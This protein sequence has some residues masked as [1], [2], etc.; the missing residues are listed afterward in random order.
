MPG[1][2]VPDDEPFAM[3]AIGLLV[4]RIGAHVAD[5]RAGECHQLPGVGRIRENL[6]IAGHGGVE[7]HFTGSQ[8]SRTD[9]PAPEQGAVFQGQQGRIVQENLREES[10]VSVG[11]VGRDPSQMQGAR[12]G[13]DCIGK[14][15]GLQGENLPFS[16]ARAVLPQRPLDAGRRMPQDA[17]P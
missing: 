16:S 2:H 6:L 3:D 9:R 8:A 15:G 10:R 4:A 5:V 17:A 11:T 7:H 13:G 1:W 14:P 12:L